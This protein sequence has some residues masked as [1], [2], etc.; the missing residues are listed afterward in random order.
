MAYYYNPNIHPFKEF[1]KR[2]NALRDY[3]SQ[4]KINLLIDEEYG[5]RDFLREVVN[6]EDQRCGICYRMRLTETARKAVSEG[7]GYFSTTLLVSPYQNHELLKSIGHEIA[8]KYNLTFVDQ[9]W[10]SG[11]K[12]A[13]SQARETGLY[14]Q[15]YCGCIYSEEERYKNKK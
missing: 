13:Q 3:C 9:D 10:R 2:M 8:E 15:P 6:K 4:E 14:M 5:L 12:E 1:E 7:I 11:F